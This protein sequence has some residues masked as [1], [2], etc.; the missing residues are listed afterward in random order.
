[1]FLIRHND[2]QALLPP[3]AGRRMST[4]VPERSIFRL[5]SLFPSKNP[6]YSPLFPHLSLSAASLPLLV[7]FLAEH[8][9]ARSQARVVRGAG[10]FL[11][12]PNTLCYTGGWVGAKK[13]GVGA[14]GGG[15]DGQRLVES[16][17]KTKNNLRLNFILH[18]TFQKV[19]SQKPNYF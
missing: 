8:R 10:G 16:G 19:T 6:F 7:L 11:L 12:V 4:L 13:K 5:P 14:K 2:V 1:M 17:H 15:E 9:L 18:L 3:H